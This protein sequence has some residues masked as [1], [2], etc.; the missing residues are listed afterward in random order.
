MNRGTESRRVMTAYATLA[1]MGALS[2][3]GTPPA[4]PTAPPP[5]PAA[6]PVPPAGSGP[7]I[8]PMRLA[9][10]QPLPKADEGATP[11]AVN[12]ALV[13]L[14]HKLFFEPKLS[15]TGRVSCESCHVLANGGMDGIALSKG[16]DG[17]P[18]RRNTPTVFNAALSSSFGWTG[19]ADTLEHFLGPHLGQAKIMGAT[20]AK[21]EQLRKDKAYE[22]LFGTAFPGDLRAFRAENAAIA[23]STYLRRLVTPSPWD[24][25]LLGDQKAL[26]D[27]QKKGFN[28][29][30]DTGCM[31]C[32]GGVNL[33]GMLVQ[34]L[35]LIA[36]WP[37]PDGGTVDLGRYETTKSEDDRMMFR[38]APLRN[39]AR[40]AP[41]SV[42]GSI[43]A[44]DQMVK[45]M[46][47]H[48]LARDLSD[49]DA[50]SIEAFLTALTGEPPS[51]L[52]ARP[53]VR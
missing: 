26:S 37:S 32:H 36:P 44:L 11:N 5:R 53:A 45:L 39:I 48:Q 35:G 41:Y 8:D 31:T 3:E 23:L 10:F 14:G 49:A 20:D 40:T 2:C 19:Q 30:A 51:D 47:H 4:P 18:L 43:P 22:K 25:F 13:E 15:S 29:F 7:V 1:L 17:K 16:I 42:D 52:I 38:S 9:V 34:K 46:A 24:R 12:D 50:R 27:E 21:F 6:A 28:L 33:G